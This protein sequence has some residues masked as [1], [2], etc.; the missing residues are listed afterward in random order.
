MPRES[1]TIIASNLSEQI[2][3][4]RATALTDLALRPRIAFDLL[5]ISVSRCVGY[6][7]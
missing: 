2:R 5:K 6:F 7:Y 3:A 4:S 1:L